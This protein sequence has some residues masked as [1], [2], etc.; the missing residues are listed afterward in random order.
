M[1]LNVLHSSETLNSSNV[2][3]EQNQTGHTKM[4]SLWIKK[5]TYY[6]KLFN[7]VLLKLLKEILQQL[8]NLIN[9]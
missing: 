9:T 6:F 1:M 5:S 8:E 7:T 4:C 3:I 2:Y